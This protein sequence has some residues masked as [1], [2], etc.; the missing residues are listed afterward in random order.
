MLLCAADHLGST[1]AVSEHVPTLVSAVC[2]RPTA[3]I[4]AATLLLLQSLCQSKPSSR[5]DAEQQNI[6]ACTFLALP[7]AG[8]H[9]S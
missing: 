5:A 7:L 8:G 9:N 2:R 4:A 3:F 1:Y 6:C